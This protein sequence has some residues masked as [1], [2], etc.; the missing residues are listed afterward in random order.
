MDDAHERRAVHPGPAPPRRERRGTPRT[1]SPAGSTST[2][3][4]RAMAEARARRRAARARPAC[5]PTSCT[6]RCCAARSR[7]AQLALDVADRHWIPVVRNWRLN[8]RH[9][10]ALQGKNKK[11]TLEAY[12]E[13]QF[14]LWRRSLRHPA[15]ADRPRRRVRADARPAL[16]LRC[17]PRPTRSPSASRTS[18]HRLLPYWEDVIVAGPARRQDGAR[19]RARQLA[20]RAGQAPRRHLRRR[21]RRAQHPDRH[22]AGLPARRRPQADR[23]AAASTSTRRPRPTAAAAVATQGKK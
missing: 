21:H 10:G 15:A 1:C 7:T 18:S 19:R 14:M 6:P 9:Y 5:C 4:R 20:A 11:Q 3:P 16:R 2:C 12:G 13:E 23:A 8:E 22:P 17:R